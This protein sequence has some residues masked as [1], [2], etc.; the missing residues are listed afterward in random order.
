MVKQII[1]CLTIDILYD[2]IPCF[3]AKSD[4]LQRFVTIKT[5]LI[6]HMLYKSIIFALRVIDKMKCIVN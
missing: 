6:L 4:P 1:I 2:S 3:L 5:T